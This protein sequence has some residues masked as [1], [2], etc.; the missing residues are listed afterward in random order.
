[1]SFDG[2]RQADIPARALQA[3]RS[4]L[5]SPKALVLGF[6]NLV[7]SQVLGNK[8]H[9]ILQSSMN[10]RLVEF[11]LIPLLSEENPAGDDATEKSSQKY[12]DGFQHLIRPQKYFQ[13]APA[14]GEWLNQGHQNTPR[15]GVQP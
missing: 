3:S 9:G 2:D 15:R 12:R 10:V 8:R 14:G 4:I 5:S 13:P 6:D 11:H 1:L 7:E